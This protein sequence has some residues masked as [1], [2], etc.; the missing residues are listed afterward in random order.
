M[1]HPCTRILG[2]AASYEQG[3]TGH[4]LLDLGPHLA[5]RATL[6]KWY[7]PDPIPKS[8][9]NRPLDR[10]WLIAT[11]RPTTSTIVLRP[12]PMPCGA[13]RTEG[14]HFP[15]PPEPRPPQSF[16]EEATAHRF[17]AQDTRI[18]TQNLCPPGCCTRPPHHRYPTPHLRYHVA[19]PLTQVAET[20][21]PPFPGVKHYPCSNPCIAKR[22]CQC[23]LVV[24]LRLDNH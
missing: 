15:R 11:T 1:R 3:T 8:T 2:E 22:D 17:P 6:V 10:P 13:S 24:N 21:G 14:D 16:A 12:S 9:R 20:Y 23:T 5:E 7:N 18:W 4:W 19:P